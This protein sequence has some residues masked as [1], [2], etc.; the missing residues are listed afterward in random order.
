MQQQPVFRESP[1]VD[2]AGFW[3]RFGAMMVDIAILWGFYY[4]LDGFWNL[5]SGLPWTGITQAMVE[6]GTTTVPLWWLRLIVFFLMQLIY[7]TGFWAWRGQ[8]PGKMLFRLK[9]VRFDATPIGWGGAFLRYCAYIISAFPL[10]I[11]FFWM[12]FNSRRQG[13][14]DKIAETFVIRIPTRREIESYKNPVD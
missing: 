2:Y 6:Q 9:V 7:F 3:W 5:A 11:G 13:L 10:F 1:T 12:T 8:T 14:H 4:L